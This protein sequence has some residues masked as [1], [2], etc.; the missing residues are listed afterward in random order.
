[1]ETEA[2]WCFT[3]NA[4]VNTITMLVSWARLYGHNPSDVTRRLLKKS[5][6]ET[7]CS[8]SSRHHL[9]TPDSTSLPVYTKMDR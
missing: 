5:V 7:Q 8:G 6:H 2:Q 9:D 4:F 3:S 1:M